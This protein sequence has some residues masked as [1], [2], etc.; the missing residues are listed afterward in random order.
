M[1]ILFLVGL[2][3]F[4]ICYAVVGIA[5]GLRMLDMQSIFDI[6]D[7]SLLYL[8]VSGGLA[9]L[10]VEYFHRKYQNQP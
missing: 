10:I 7:N 1:G 5:H 2:F 3:D 4:D 6:C 8:F 9:V